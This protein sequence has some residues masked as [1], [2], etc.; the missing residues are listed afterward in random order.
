MFY[1]KICVVRK[2]SI[3]FLIKIY[4][5]FYFPGKFLTEPASPILGSNRHKFINISRSLANGEIG[6]FNSPVVMSVE[7]PLEENSKTI[8]LQLMR[9]GT[10]NEAIVTWIIRSNNILFNNH[11]VVEMNGT[12][13]FDKGRTFMHEMIIE[14]EG[15]F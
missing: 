4:L 5:Y 6:F 7:E 9:D 11:D 8:N 1:I 14:M 13:K 2:R 12:V 10:H 15:I 3:P